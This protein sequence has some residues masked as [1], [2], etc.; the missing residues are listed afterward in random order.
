MSASAIPAGWPHA[1]ASDQVSAAGMVWHVQRFGSGP[2][3]LLLHGTA[4]STH[5]FRELAAL[6]AQDFHVVAA[7]LPGHGYS[8]ALDA[9]TLPRV[10]EGLAALVSKIG[11]KPALAVG[12]SAGAA[13]ALRMAVDG[14]IEPRAVIGLAPALKPYGG[15]ADGLASNLA[16]LAFLNPL[17]P[18]LMS[19]RAEPDRVGRLIAKTGSRLDDAGVEYYARLFKR[20]DHV[21]GAL[22]LMAHWKLRPLLDDLPYLTLPARFIVGETDYATPP[23][24]AEAAARRIRD[25]RVERLTGLGHLAHEQDPEAVAGHIR[26]AARDAGLI[27]DA[28]PR[29]ASG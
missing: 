4:A 17:T 20:A 16:K 14:L 23:G 8:G 29:A 19:M 13:I 10:A 12:H 2:A 18:R 26:S 22:R 21:R 27:P 15:A 3:I 11:V 25:S 1:E 9:P 28:P 6:L 5:S 24:D 7:D